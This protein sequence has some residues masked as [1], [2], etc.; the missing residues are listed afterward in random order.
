MSVKFKSEV[1]QLSSSRKIAYLLFFLMEFFLFLGMW[2][3]SAT[4]TWTISALLP[5]LQEDQPEGQLQGQ[6]GTSVCPREDEV[7]HLKG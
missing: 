5:G 7:G 2:H 3:G 4:F 1:N 6:D